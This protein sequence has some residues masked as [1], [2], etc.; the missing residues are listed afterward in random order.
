MQIQWHIFNK[1]FIHRMYTSEILPPLLEVKVSIGGNSEMGNFL[2]PNL[3]MTI[4][5]QTPTSNQNL[6]F[7]KHESFE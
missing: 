7:D 5:I 1:A 4:M 3:L 2:T 6:V